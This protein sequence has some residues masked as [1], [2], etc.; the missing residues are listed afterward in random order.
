MAPLVAAAGQCKGSR[1]QECGGAHEAGMLAQ[2]FCH[3][4]VIDC[5][6][7]S[8]SCTVPV[9]EGRHWICTVGLATASTWPCMTAHVKQMMRLKVSLQRC[10]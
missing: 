8:D 6:S 1:R 10:S 2:C 5:V 4:T 9:Q 3:L 7:L